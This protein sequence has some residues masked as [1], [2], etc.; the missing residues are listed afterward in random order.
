LSF[1]T[2]IVGAGPAGLLAACIAGRRGKTVLLLDK[3]SNPGKKL[4][5][6]GKGRCNLTSGC[7]TEEFFENIITNGK[8][9]RN[10]FYK[11]DNHDTVSFFNDIGL[12]TVLERGKRIFPSSG[13]AKDVLK[14][15]EKEMIARGVVFQ[16]KY[17]DAVETADR[18]F[19]IYLKNGIIKSDTLILAMGGKAYPG[20][21]SD[22]HGFDI[23]TSLG[24]SVSTLRPSLVQMRTGSI[25]LSKAAGLLLKNVRTEFYDT[26]GKKVFEQFGELEIIQ[27][28]VSGAVI[29]TASALIRKINGY[30]LRIDLKPA[31]NEEQIMNRINREL[32]KKPNLRIKEL[33]RKL[34]P[35][36]MITVFTEYLS[37]SADFHVR[38]LKIDQKRELIRLLKT[39]EVKLVGYKS[40]R[41]ALITA[42]GVDVNEIDPHTME[43]KLVKGLF[44]AGEMIDLD[45]LTG[46]FNLQIAWTTGYTAGMNC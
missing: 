8:F 22:G 43:S 32:E 12:K 37:L 42:G 7:T 19:N 24:H 40:F 33:L 26:K 15:L 11:F 5:L 46:G 16:Q 10:S 29:L 21:G 30:T 36:E 1:E 4:L 25:P 38:K 27:N 9:L 14:A 13:R 44:F 2:V 28:G 18:R 35:A 45:G 23:A 6:T 3:N 31:L 41:N 20:T 39:L 17:V 34:L